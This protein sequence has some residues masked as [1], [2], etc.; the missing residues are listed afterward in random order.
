MHKKCFKCNE[1]KSLDNFYKQKSMKD[2]H[3]NKCI[4][5]TKKDVTQNRLDKI[6][7]YRSFDRARASQPKRKIM[8]KRVISQ[9][10]AQ[11]PNRRKAQII[12][13]NA[14]RDKKI[15][16]YPCIVCGI[17]KVEAHHPDYD[18]PLD[19]IW[20]CPAHHK[21]THAMAKVML[22]AA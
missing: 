15:E 14:L 20:M 7:Y 4:D 5:C 19:V 12:L 13:G 8:A 17:E 16:K 3:V 9:W 6:D 2:G 22:K 18:R 11:F 10:K 1:I 21:Q